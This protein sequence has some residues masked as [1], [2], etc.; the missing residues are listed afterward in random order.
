MLLNSFGTIFYN[1]STPDF[2]RK[3]IL[4]TSICLVTP[5]VICSFTAP[6][7]KSLVIISISVSS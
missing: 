6:V 4:K 1:I 2:V 3:V 7:Y 5:G